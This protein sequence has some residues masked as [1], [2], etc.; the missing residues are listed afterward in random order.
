MRKQYLAAI[1]ALALLTPPALQAMTEDQEDIKALEEMF[2]EDQPDESD[3]WRQDRLLTTATGSQKPLRL[4]PSVA[5][6]VTKEEIEAIGATSLDEILETVPGLHV[7]PSGSS[8]FSPIWSIRGVHTSVNPQVL[9]LINGVPFSQNYAGNRGT[10]FRMPVAMISRVE[11]IR[12]PGSALHGADAYSGVVNVITKDNFE[13][14]GTKMGVRGG[15]F[16]TYDGWVQH[17]GQ[18]GGWDVAMGVEWSKSDGDDD[19]IVDQDFLHAIGAAALSNAPG[20]MDTQYEN[21]DAN[22][23]LRK[24][25][26]EFPSLWKKAS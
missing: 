17:G 19:R 6:V 12:G 22:L 4:A 18:Y 24:G 23:G 16:D 14:D 26:V 5:T 10:G 11:V 1:L 25:G 20:P 7:V 9:L 15:S 2:P 21:L 8:F 3:F 13:I